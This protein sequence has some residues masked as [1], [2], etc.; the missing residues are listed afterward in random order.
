MPI[1]ARIIHSDLTLE[2]DDQAITMT[3]FRKAVDH[4]LGLIKEISGV[5][6]P[7]K[8]PASWYVDVYSGSVGLGVRAKT[9][10]YSLEEMNAIRDA[11]LKGLH[12]IEKGYRPAT[13]SDRAVEHSKQL[14][15]LVNQ[16]NEPLSV[17]VWSG[18]RSKVSLSRETAEKAT[19]LLSPVYEDEGSVDGTLEKLN[20]HG[21]REFVIFDTVTDRGIICYVDDALL[22]EAPRYFFKRVEVLGKVRY[23]HDGQPVSIHATEIIPFPDADEIPTLEQMRDLLKGA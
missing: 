2:L 17:R 15:T 14:A 3:E 4:F 9:D 12:E 11:V 6:A 19:S 18:N 10:V 21:A 22:R 23:R 7:A 20:G 5:T 16:K 1:D 13:F 8:D